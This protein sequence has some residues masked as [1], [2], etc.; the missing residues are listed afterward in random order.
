MDPKKQ[1]I[2]S[3]IGGCTSFIVIYP[4]EVIK[5]NYQFLK[6]RDK[7]YF[8]VVNNIYNTNGIRGFYR[9]LLAPMCIQG[10][11]MAFGFTLS[12]YF[13]SQIPNIK[14][15]CYLSGAIGGAL[16][17]MFIATPSENIK[18]YSIHNNV[19]GINA[20]K[21]IFNKNGIK[22]FTKGMTAIAMKESFTYSGRIGTNHYL[23]EIIKPKN[24]LE[25]SLV[26]GLSSAIATIFSTPFD[27][28]IVRLQSDYKGK[29]KN[30]IDCV[31]KIYKEE[32]IIMF[33]RGATIRSIRTAIGMSVAF[34]V[35]DFVKKLI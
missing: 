8:S 27:I 5:S 21:N 31:N 15:A 22:A 2:A 32:G 28:V 26:G 20:I 19:S 34:G 29:Y 10:P 16:T 1:L 33:F 18:T 11:R 3:T 6:H 14:Y 24:T 12:E 23:R 4:S 35:I 30:M 9:G 13:I 17:G 25:V 7:T